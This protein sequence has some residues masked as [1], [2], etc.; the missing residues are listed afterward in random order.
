[1]KTRVLLLGTTA[2]DVNI[3]VRCF[4]EV[5]DKYEVTILVEP[6]HL[7]K[8][9]TN[10]GAIAI[11]Q[12]HELSINC[13]VDYLDNY[14]HNHDILMPSGFDSVKL[15]AG[16]VDRLS[17]FIRLLALPD[18]ALIDELDDKLSFARYCETHGLPHPVTTAGTDYFNGAQSRMS[19]PLLLKHR[20]GAGKQGIRLV[21]TPAEVHTGRESSMAE[22]FIVQEYLSGYDFA[23]NGF[24]RNGSIISW[25]IQKFHSVRILGRDRLRTSTFV[26]NDEIR[27]LAEKLISMTDYSGPINIDFRYVPDENRSYFIEVNP[28]FWANTHY[29]LIDGVNFVDS[30]LDSD[31]TCVQPQHAGRTW[32]EPIKT[33]VLMICFLRFDLMRVLLSQS[34]LQLKIEMIDRLDSL[35][36]RYMTG[37]IRTTDT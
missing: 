8:V 24:C 17:V 21:R 25:S 15:I 34:V 6:Q 37:A 1:M 28:R 2:G 35:Y 22:E 9:M 27:A 26:G 20:L 32:G 4:R 19:F 23:F 11:K 5:A 29:S 33:I 10:F 16:N 12:V 31:I 30:A 36:S 3:F 7:P 18:S 13:L 14:A